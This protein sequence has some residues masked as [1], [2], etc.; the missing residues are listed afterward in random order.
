[1]AF[2]FYLSVVGYFFKIV[3]VR[4]KLYLDLPKIVREQFFII[5]F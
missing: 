2:E 3:L 4:G 1:M 5:E